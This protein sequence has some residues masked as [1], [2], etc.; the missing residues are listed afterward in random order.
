MRHRRRYHDLGLIFAKEWSE[1]RR[2]YDVLGTPI[3]ANNIGD[4]EFAWVVKAAGVRRISIHGLR[5]TC[6]SLL[7]SAGI[8][9]NV[10]RD[11]LGHR[12]VETTLTVYAHCLPGQQK[13]AARR[14]A[15]LLHGR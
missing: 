15:A 4:R 9:P 6:A 14:L 8:A 5:H 11:R 12:N 1:G 3:Q 7:L 2:R 10:V 13:D